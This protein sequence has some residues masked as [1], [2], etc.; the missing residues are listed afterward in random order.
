MPRVERVADLH[1]NNN[2]NDNYIILIG[3]RANFKS[4][5]TCS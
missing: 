4:Q 2:D 3:V 1:N 5:S